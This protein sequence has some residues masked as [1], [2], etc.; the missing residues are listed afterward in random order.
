M[1]LICRLNFVNCGL[2]LQ[3]G[4]PSLARSDS[5]LI[6]SVLLRY[7]KYLVSPVLPTPIVFLSRYF[8]VIGLR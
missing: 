4:A 8:S 3:G 5:I 1:R 7:C 2:S 6:A